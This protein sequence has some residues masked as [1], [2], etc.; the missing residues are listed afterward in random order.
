MIEAAEAGREQRQRAERAVA[1]SA[2]AVEVDRAIAAQRERADLLHLLEQLAGK[3]EVRIDD[4]SDQ[5]C[6]RRLQQDAD[7]AAAECERPRIDDRRGIE[8]GAVGGVENH[9][10]ARDLDARADRHQRD[11]GAGDAAACDR[12]AQVA[13]DPQQ[14]AVAGDQ[15]VIRGV[16]QAAFGEDGRARRERESALGNEG[17]LRREEDAAGV[18]QEEIA[19]AHIDGRAVRAAASQASDQEALRAPGLQDRG[20]EHGLRTRRG[21][22]A[23]AND[24]DVGEAAEIDRRAA[25]A[26]W[27]AGEHAALG[28]QAGIAVEGEIARV[29]RQP[30]RAL[31]IEAHGRIAHEVVGRVVLVSRTAPNHLG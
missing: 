9:I 3:R 29:D 26:G 20:V 7:L 27:R 28:P 22:A 10:P 23:A 6:G 25:P 31:E 30:L 19:R 15:E 4:R 16:G 1:E 18:V 2:R 24:M 8:R 11:R 21:R 14:R 12:R 5:A 13:A 17:D